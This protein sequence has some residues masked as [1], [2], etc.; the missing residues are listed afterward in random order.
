MSRAAALG[1]TLATT[2]PHL[3]EKLVLVGTPPSVTATAE[4]PGIDQTFWQH[5]VSLIE[6]GDYERAMPLFWARE[7]SEPDSSDLAKTF[8]RASL[9][10][11]REV[12]RVFFTVPDP[13]RDIRHLLP[14]VRVPT[15]VLHGE[16]DRVVPV[17]A[18][19][20]VARQIPGAQF[21]AFKGCG[22]MPAFTAPAEFARVVRDF[23]RPPRAV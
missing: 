2:Y 12:F 9:E 22:H 15:L 16:E 17:E 3:V 7:F 4:S 8:V 21:Y 13:G 19:R 1:V 14:A 10:M 20:W 11:P 5:V 6:A 18:G 23:L